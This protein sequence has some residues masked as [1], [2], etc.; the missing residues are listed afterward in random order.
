M[1][2]PPP[3]A[4]AARELPCGRRTAYAAQPREAATGHPALVE[5]ARLLVSEVVANVHLHTKVPLLSLEAT[6]RGHR[7]HVSVRDD[8]PNGAPW[9]PEPRTPE[10][11]A[12]AEH[13]RGLL[14]VQACADAWGTVWHGG[15]QRTGK[16]VW[17]SLSDTPGPPT[18]AA[19]TVTSAGHGGT[20]P[21]AS[22]APDR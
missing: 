18:P 6:I 7:L 9:P 15:I 1:R 2:T 11:E 13:G 21:A 5:T 12:D 19:T 3:D 17:F 22:G 8:D 4:Q 16:S 14:L 20:S 10:A